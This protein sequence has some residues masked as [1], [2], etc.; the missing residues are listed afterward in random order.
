MT[1]PRDSQVRI[2]TFPVIPC[3]KMNF[4]SSN[5]HDSGL[6]SSIVDELSIFWDPLS[7]KIYTYGNISTHFSAYQGGVIAYDT[8]NDTWIRSRYEIEGL[9]VQHMEFDSLTQEMLLFGFFKKIFASTDTLSKN[10]V[11]C[12]GTSCSGPTSKVS[13]YR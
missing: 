4:N 10:I 12:S 5:N 6:F 3:M 13:F 9:N 8:S 1:T 7:G 11:S 2:Q